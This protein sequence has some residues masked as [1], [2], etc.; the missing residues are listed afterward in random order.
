MAF[1]EERIRDAIVYGTTGGPK[2][3][4]QVVA[5]PGGAEQR[6]SNWDNALGRWDLGERKFTREQFDELNNFFRRVRGKAVGFRWKDWGDYQCS[7][8]QGRFAAVTGGFQLIKSYGDGEQRPI[9]KPVSG[10][11]TVYNSAGAALAVSMDP[12]TGICSGADLSAGCTWEGEFD[13][14]VRFDSDDLLYNLQVVERSNGRG[15]FYVS[16]LPVQELLT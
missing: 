9:R 1:I 4:T 16:A 13:V 15:L 5:S 11:L 6:N 2:F 12:T 3:S 10:S 14:P 7:R 8:S